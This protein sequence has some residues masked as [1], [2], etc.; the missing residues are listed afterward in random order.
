MPFTLAPIDIPDDF[1]WNGKCFHLTYATHVSKVDLLAAARRATSTQIVG[2][3]L[4][5]EDTAEYG[6]EGQQLS[7]G[8][9][10]THFAMI[11][12]SRIKLKGSRKF[13]IFVSDPTDP[14]GLPRQLH[15][16]VQPKV[17][18]VQ[19][20]QLFTQYHAGRKYNIAT[21]KMAYKPPILHEYHLPP[22]FEFHR[23]ILEDVVAAP[24]L[25]EACIAG[26]VRP[27]SIS[28]IKS[29]RD[30]QSKIKRYKHKFDPASFSLREPP[31]WQVIHVHG[32]SGFGKSKWAAARFKNPCY[33]CPFD[34]IG[35]LE[36]LSRVFDPEQHDGIVL[37]EAN[38]TFLTRQ[39][40]I[41]LFDADEPC[42]MDVRFKSFTLPAGIKKVLCSNEPP[43]NLYPPD[44]HGAIARR[45]I[46]LHITAP[47]YPSPTPLPLRPPLAPVIW[48]TP[49]TQT[50]PHG[51]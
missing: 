44:P 23:A 45:F 34:S 16:H 22:A 10:H 21:G 36:A 27:R 18:M 28:D 12:A 13:D 50:G 4:A 39:Q 42:T 49:A 7:E 3:S 15:P 19:M 43:S 9:E 33:V 17:T 20:E 2:W 32:P 11:F 6:D 46:P 51:P 30:E 25:F 26:Q 31:S 40:V 38:L 41:A 5:Q 24:S 35:C 47:T 29:L 8:Y 14:T 37:D 48:L 1:E